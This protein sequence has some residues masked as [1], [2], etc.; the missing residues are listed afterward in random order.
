MP[1]IETYPWGN[2]V[3]ALHQVS[4]CIICLTWINLKGDTGH[5]KSGGPNTIP[6]YTTGLSAQSKSGG[7]SSHLGH[8]KLQ[9]ARTS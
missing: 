8:Y 5:P 4:A 1:V 6:A 7:N 9:G 3:Q 2:K